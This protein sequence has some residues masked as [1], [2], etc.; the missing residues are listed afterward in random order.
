MKRTYIQ[1]N[2]RCL[3]MRGREHLLVMSSETSVTTPVGGTPGAFDVK[4]EQITLPWQQ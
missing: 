2:A 4:S 3:A 1:P